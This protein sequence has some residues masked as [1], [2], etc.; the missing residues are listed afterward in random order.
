[1]NKNKRFLVLVALCVSIPFLAKGG[2]YFVKVNATGNGSGSDWGNAMG[3]KTF[4][5]KLF[6]A[7]SGDV[8]YVAEGTYYPEYEEISGGEGDEEHYLNPDNIP[9]RPFMLN[10]GVKIIGSYKSIPTGTAHDLVN[11]RNHINTSSGELIPTTIFSGDADKNGVLYDVNDVPVIM[12]AD[13]AAAGDTVYINGIEVT[14]ASRA[15]LS[16]VK[17]NI[18]LEYCKVTKNRFT[19]KNTANDPAGAFLFDEGSLTIR[20]SAITDNEGTGSGYQNQ[21]IGKG[22]GVIKM[23]NADLSIYNSVISGNNTG[24]FTASAVY[25]RSTKTLKIYNT[26]ISNNTTACERHGAVYVGGSGKA[27]IINSTVTGNESTHATPLGAGIAI[28]GKGTT[29]LHWGPQP[30]TIDNTIVSGNEAHDI[31]MLKTFIIDE[32]SLISPVNP[33]FDR[34]DLFDENIFLQ[35]ENDLYQHFIAKYSIIGKYFSNGS[36]AATDVSFSAST[37][38]GSLAHDK[39]ATKTKA[40]LKTTSP[41]NYAIDKGNP[42]Y[43]SSGSAPDGL[44]MDQRGEAR[45]ATPSIG[46]YEVEDEGVE[47]ELKVF[48]QGP[49]KSDG[50]VMTNYIQTA[51]PVYSSFDEPRLPTT[52]PYRGNVTYAGINNVVTAGAV[53]DWIQ[54]EIWSVNMGAYAKVILDEKALLLRPDGTIL[55]I[56]GQ[57]PKFKAQSGAVRII[58]K[59]RN[60][61]GV[62]SNEITSFTGGSVG[63]DFTT[64]VNKAVAGSGAAMVKVGDKWCLWAGDTNM[65]GAINAIDNMVLV[66]N[67]TSMKE[68]EY[69]VADLNMDGAANMIDNTLRNAVF[70]L[71]LESILMDF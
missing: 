42:A 59:H 27:Y 50:T 25:F 44:N 55:D 2:N 45:K 46:A 3:N 18:V 69:S 32:W 31:I 33:S 65:D 71:G 48:L 6:D 40:L 70:T 37:H 11:D 4:C 35:S 24:R 57:K 8:F 19:Y 34:V 52:D 1:M 51:D 16:A 36:S 66:N 10:E 22:W 17:T 68:D 9:R 29:G 63:Y 67:F 23:A 13:N 41:L 56:N 39:G 7:V 61:L 60:H 64:D 15:G 38:L 14:H 28:E 62:M 21:D 20:K 49:L 12:Y 54:V 5:N 30:F 53:V 26:T 58:I 43:A 47:L